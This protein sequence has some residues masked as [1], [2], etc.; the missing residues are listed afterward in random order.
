MSVLNWYAIKLARGLLKLAVIVPRLP[1]CSGKILRATMV[2]IANGQEFKM[3][4]TIDDLVILD[5]IK[6]SYKVGVCKI[7]LLSFFNLNELFGN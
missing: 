5:E 7:D 1:D 6:A 4:A 2:K 3:P